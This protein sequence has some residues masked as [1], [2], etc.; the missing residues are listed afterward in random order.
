[1]IGMTSLFIGALGNLFFIT[2]ASLQ[3]WFPVI[4][5]GISGFLGY[6]AVIPMT[7][8]AYIADVSS[9][10]EN[11]TIRMV[12]VSVCGQFAM[13]IGS[14]LTGEASKSVIISQIS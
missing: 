9:T 6:L 8:A 5:S 7:C 2:L 3:M 11:L 14:L 4:T 12:I 10:P 13:I 1:M